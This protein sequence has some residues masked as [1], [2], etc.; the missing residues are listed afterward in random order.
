MGE[1]FN[2]VVGEILL[3]LLTAALIASRSSV[4]EGVRKVGN[5]PKTKLRYRIKIALNH[6]RTSKKLP[7]K[8]E[9]FRFSG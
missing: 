5:K 9:P 3:V 6:P 1:F 2:W 7:Y 4:F 8:G